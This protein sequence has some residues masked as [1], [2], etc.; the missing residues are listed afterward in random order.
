MPVTAR[1]RPDRTLECLVFSNVRPGPEMSGIEDWLK[2]HGI[3]PATI[4]TSAV[5]GYDPLSD[6]WIFPVIEQPI[7]ID[8]ETGDVVTTPTRVAVQS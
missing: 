1:F 4:S 6:E 2:I 7:R 8:N 5:I 3:D